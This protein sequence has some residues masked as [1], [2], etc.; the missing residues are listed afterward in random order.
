MTRYH[1]HLVL[2]PPETLRQITGSST[3]KMDIVSTGHATENHFPFLKL[4]ADIRNIIYRF[5]LPTTIIRPS[6]VREGKILLEYYSVEWFTYRDA[7]NEVVRGPRRKGLD[8]F[9]NF[10]L[11]NWQVY[12]E[13]SYFLYQDCQFL[14]VVEKHQIAYLDSQAYR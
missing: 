12:N 9:A 13:A 2:H 11:T 5:C 1:H 10:L 14:I 4:P 6:F 8:P 7:F 3:L